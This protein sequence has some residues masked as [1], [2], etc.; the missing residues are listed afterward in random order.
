MPVQTIDCKAKRASS[1]MHHQEFKFSWNISRCKLE[2]SQ[3]YEEIKSEAFVDWSREYFTR[4]DETKS[5]KLTP[6]LG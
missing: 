1:G 3:I 2:K 5:K 6:S 4:K